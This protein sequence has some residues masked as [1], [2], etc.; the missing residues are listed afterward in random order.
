VLKVTSVWW[1]PAAICSD[2][3]LKTI[4]LFLQEV[5]GTRG[6][7]AI[8]F[9]PDAGDVLMCDFIGFIAPEMTKVRRV[10]VLSPR[11]RDVIPGTYLVVPVS[12][13]PPSRPEP[14]HHEFPPRG[15]DFFDHGQSVWAKAG[16]GDLRR[17]APA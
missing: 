1:R 16:Y 11:S 6:L 2:L 14:H 8:T 15:Y 12:K 3:F 5:P 7:M 10:I 13:T 4:T 17:I 9:V